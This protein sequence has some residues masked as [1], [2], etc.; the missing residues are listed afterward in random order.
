MRLDNTVCV[1]TG[2]ASGLG[3]STVRTLV[4]QGAKVSIWDLNEELGNNL[5]NELGSNTIFCS[6]DVTNIE[7]VVTSIQKTVEK[8][9]S[10]N[11]CV[12][13]AGVLFGMRTIAK[14]K[15]HSL[16]AFERVIK[17]NVIGTFNVC[18]LIAKQ[19]ASQPL[20]NSNDERGII[21]NVASIAGYEGQQGQVAYA[22]SKGAILGLNLPLARDLA[23]FKIRVATLAPGLFRTPMSEKV[24]TKDS[25]L[26]LKAVPIKRFGEPEEFA[27]AVK[28]IIENQ[29]MTGS[30]IRLDGGIRLPFI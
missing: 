3:A 20:A 1:V 5:V 12:N 30:V 15:V 29:Y 13:C 14:D 28:F 4:A 26:L 17:I 11:A 25:D 16:E 22:S 18:R 7:H 8:F 23:Y 19:M 27:H 10:I 6:V 24:S 2:G 21:I 9:G